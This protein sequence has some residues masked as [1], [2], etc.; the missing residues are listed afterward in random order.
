LLNI[1]QPVGVVAAIT[2]WNFPAA[3]VTRKIAPAIA[4]GCAVI[5]KPSELTPLTAL[6]LA[7]LA[8][9]AGLPAG[10]FQ[11]LTSSQSALIGQ[12]LCQSSQ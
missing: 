9:K 2:P 4:A 11:V 1:R 7:D 6:A 8:A 3:M 12:L 5:L 10:L